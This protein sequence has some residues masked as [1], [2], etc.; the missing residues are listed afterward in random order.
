M[1]G[2]GALALAIASLCA[3]VGGS[4][5]SLDVAL[6]GIAVSTPPA[7]RTISI[8]P[9]ADA[10]VA[11]DDP[12][13]NFGASQLL[14]VQAASSSEH[15]TFLRFSLSALPTGATIT[16]AT[17]RLYLESAPA[18]TRLYELRRVDAS[19]TESGITWNNRP[20]VAGSV[21]ESVWTGTTSG[22]FM[23]FDVTADISLLL[24][25]SN[26]GWRIADAGPVPGSTQEG[27]FRSQEAATR[28]P[29]LVV[30]YVAP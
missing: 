25:R 28:R 30:T 29:V 20:A 7:P 18:Q 9:E 11:E 1:S 24:S 23:M 14:S 21:T 27:T 10:H 4:A 3:I 17:V 22:A 15:Q 6:S 13:T 2:T 8:A 5:S 19:W 12:A 16:E 26:D